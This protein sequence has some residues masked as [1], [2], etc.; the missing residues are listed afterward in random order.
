[1]PPATDIPE[2]GIKRN[3]KKTVRSGR[4]NWTGGGPLSRR[5]TALKFPRKSQKPDMQYRPTV[6]TEGLRRN[7]E[8]DGS[9]SACSV[10]QKT[11]AKF[12]VYRHLKRGLE[13]KGVRME[14]L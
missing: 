1:M 7:A 9:T 6:H 10:K 14:G 12:K 4:M 3:R 11:K 8:G 13:R 2:N 5:Q